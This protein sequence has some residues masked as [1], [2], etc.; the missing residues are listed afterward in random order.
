MN[1]KRDETAQD[2][3]SIKKAQLFLNP[4]TFTLIIVS[5]YLFSFKAV[6]KDHIGPQLY[7]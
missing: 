6:L 7:N 2:F 4:V 3:F 1:T 5:V